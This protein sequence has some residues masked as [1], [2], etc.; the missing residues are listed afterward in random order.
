MRG[1][2]IRRL[3]AAG[4][5]S[6]VERRPEG[7]KIEP[8]PLVFPVPRTCI[9]AERARQSEACFRT[10]SGTTTGAVRGKRDLTSDYPGKLSCTQGSI[11]HRYGL[12]HCEGKRTNA[13]GRLKGDMLRPV[14]T[15]VLMF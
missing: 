7:D 9:T 8:V 3:P 6:S 5:T 11:W 12:S 2:G 14:S 10:A 1:R 4:R 15:T 13:N